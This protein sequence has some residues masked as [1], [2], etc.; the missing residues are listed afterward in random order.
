MNFFLFNIEKCTFIYK[1]SNDI[2]LIRIDI[3][4]NLIY[5]N[6]NVYILILSIIIYL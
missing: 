2:K 1:N 4:K 3:N 6:P 5:I